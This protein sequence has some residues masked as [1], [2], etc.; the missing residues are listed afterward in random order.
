[1]LF[2]EK[3]AHYSYYKHGPLMRTVLGQLQVQ[4]LDY[5]YTLQGWLKGINPAMGGSL[6]NGTD[7]T[8]AF[9]VTQDVYGFSLH[10]YNKDYRAIGFTPQATSVISGLGTN[11]APLYN[12]NIAAMAVNIPQLSATKLY[13]YH[14]DQLNRIVAMDMYNG[15]NPNAGTPAILRISK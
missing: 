1:L 2:P 3:E 9:P 10:Y 11:A 4:G 7:T 15:L 14:Y 5:A 12:G 8:E 13:N 6:T